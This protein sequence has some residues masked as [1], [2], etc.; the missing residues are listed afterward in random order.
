MPKGIHFCYFILHSKPGLESSSNFYIRSL[1]LW[2]DQISEP[3]SKWHWIMFFADLQYFWNLLHSWDRPVRHIHVLYINSRKC[4]SHDF[5]PGF[6][7]PSISAG[8]PSL[9]FS[10]RAPIVPSSSS[11][12]PTTFSPRMLLPLSLTVALFKII[13][14]INFCPSSLTCQGIFDC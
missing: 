2:N 3:S 11:L 13:W 12:P 5:S 8:L 1:Y 10:M 4:N 14:P 7:C 6:S 9:T